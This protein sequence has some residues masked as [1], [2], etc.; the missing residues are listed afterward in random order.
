MGRVSGRLALPVS[1]QAGTWLLI[2]VYLVCL[3]H[4]GP[5]FEFWVDGVFGEAP[6]PCPPCSAGWRSGGPARAVP[7]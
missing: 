2:G 7:R 6:R 4:H 3:L 5:N 1:L